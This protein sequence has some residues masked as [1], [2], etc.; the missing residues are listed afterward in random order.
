MGF[1]FAVI[2]TSLLGVPGNEL[3]CGQKTLKLKLTLSAWGPPIGTDQY[4]AS[5]RD[6][7]HA[8]RFAIKDPLERVA[9]FEAVFDILF[10]EDHALLKDLRFSIPIALPIYRASGEVVER[11][12]G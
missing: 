2:K 8:I 1:A 11:P 7:A 4:W 6:P 5:N 12:R 10:H 3:I 9:R